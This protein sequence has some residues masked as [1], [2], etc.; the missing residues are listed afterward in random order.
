MVVLMQPPQ[1]RSKP[2]DTPKKKQNVLRQPHRSALR[3]P[4]RPLAQQDCI[5]LCLKA[6]GSRNC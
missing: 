5:T 4:K 3:H 1:L 2:R 6:A